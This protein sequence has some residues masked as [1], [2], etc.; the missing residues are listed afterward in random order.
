MFAARIPGWARYLQP[1]V[2]QAAWWT[3]KSTK[4]VR[5]QLAAGVARASV[6][7][8]PA[9]PW[10]AGLGVDTV[11]AR[12]GATCLEG[13]MVRQR[14]LAAHGVLRDVVIGLPATGFGSTPA[15]AWVDGFDPVGSDLHAELYRIPAQ[16]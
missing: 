13:A 9:L 4:D 6:V 16:A 10:R 12:M 2:F 8:P 1:C 14:W 11:I 15:H 5:R 3:F 7:S